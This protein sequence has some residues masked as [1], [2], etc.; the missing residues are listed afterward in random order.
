[1]TL[2]ISPM[3]DIG[4]EEKEEVEKPEV[5]IDLDAEPSSDTE[6]FMGGA[7]VP[8]DEVEKTPGKQRIPF[9][10]TPETK[11]YDE[12]EEVRG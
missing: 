1:M 4:D 10:N 12:N 5:D 7:H 11:P 8:Q 2:E 9:Q 6:P 3:E